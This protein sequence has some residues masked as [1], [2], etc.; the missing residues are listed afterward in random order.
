MRFTHDEGDVRTSEFSAVDVITPGRSEG[1][2]RTT[3]RRS[4][5]P[6]LRPERTPLDSPGKHADVN[7]N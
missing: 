6:D 7:P 4:R 5:R 2:E 3:R 1:R